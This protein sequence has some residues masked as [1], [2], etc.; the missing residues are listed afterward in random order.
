M[1]RYIENQDKRF[2]TFVA[3]RVAAIH[4]ASSLTQWNYVNTE[5]NPADDASR[6]ASADCLERWL[7]GL[8][9]LG[10]SEDAWP[11]PPADMNVSIDDADPEVKGPIVCAVY[12]SD[13]NPLE[14]IIKRYSSW[15]RL[16]RIVAWMLRYKAN[17]LRNIRKR[18]EGEILVDE[19]TGQVTPIDVDEIKNAETEILKCAQSESFKDECRLLEDNQPKES[20]GKGK[21]KK[22]SKIFNLDP[23]MNQGLLRVGGRLENALIS[24]DAKH[25]V[26]LP[27]NHHVVT[28]IV[29]HYRHLSGHSGVE[30]TLSLIRQTYWIIKGR[31]TVQTI[32]NQCVSCKKRQAPMAKQK[33]ANLPQDRTTPSKSPFTYTGVDCFGPFGVRRGRTKVKRYGVLFTCLNIRAIHLEVASSLNTESFINALRKF[34]A[35]RGQPEEI[36]SDNGGNFVSGEKELREAVRDWNQSQI[37]KF[38]L[39]RSIK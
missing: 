9:F 6:G 13:P 19:P 38:L 11:K 35:R 18:R 26:I 15:D 29:N 2:H 4:N 30:Y 1:L 39:Q 17:L 32:L 36:R 3:N 28:L 8:E 12:R 16:R 23:V 5:L 10:Q 25:P 24:Q 14:E 31:Q 7:L 34:I 37:H 20:K 21:I 27:K 33:M 22:D